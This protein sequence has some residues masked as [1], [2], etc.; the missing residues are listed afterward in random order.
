MVAA[1]AAL[2]CKSIQ[3]GVTDEWCNTNCNAPTPFCPDDICQCDT[4]PTPLP[5]P[6]PE[7]APTPAAPTPPPPTPAAPSPPP[8]PTPAPAPTP[9]PSGVAAALEAALDSAEAAFNKEILLYMTPQN[10]WMPSTVYRYPD[11]R[12]AIKQMFVLSYDLLCDPNA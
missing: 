11:L 2:T 6:T 4:T 8:A 5:V 1:G 7:P 9:F 3:S 10:Q 12:V